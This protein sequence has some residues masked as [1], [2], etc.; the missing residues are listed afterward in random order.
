MIL[1]SARTRRR[2]GRT[3]S[4]VRG[5]FAAAAVLLAAAAVFAPAQQASAASTSCS[6]GDQAAGTYKNSIC[7]IDLA[8]YDSAL[9]Q[10][11]AGQPFDLTLDGGYQ[12]SF[13]LTSTGGGGGQRNFLPSALPVVGAPGTVGTL[14]GLSYVGTQGLPAL[15]AQRGAANSTTRLTISNIALTSPGGNPVNNFA[16]IGADAEFTDAPAGGTSQQEA[17]TWESNVPIDVIDHGTPSPGVNGCPI[18]VP[19]D[20]TTV[21]SCVP[22]TAAGEERAL[23]TVVRAIQ[24]TTF[25][26]NIY[27]GQAGEREAVAFGIMTAKVTLDKNVAGRISATDSFA[28][29]ITSDLDEVLGS[30]TTGTGPSSTTG[31]TVVVPNLPGGEFT[32]AETAE[33]GNLEEYTAAWTCT[34][35]VT[36]SSTTLPNGPGFQQV[37]VPQPGDDITCRIVNT[38]D[39]YTV[40]KT[41]SA[42]TGRA[43]DVLNYTITVTNTGPGDYTA[44]QPARLSDD[45]ADVLDDATYNGDATQGATVAGNTL[46]WSGPLASGQSLTIKYSVT[47][48]AAG[49]LNVRNTVLARSP[50]GSCD[51]ASACAVETLLVRPAGPQVSTGGSAGDSTGGSAGLSHTG[52]SVPWMPLMFGVLLALAGSAGL[53]VSRTSRER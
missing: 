39:S 53:F 17:I 1:S 47:A 42:T 19:G 44:N 23:A 31:S 51:P 52:G 15:Y 29:S 18:P 26:Q 22:T 45:L 11:P 3:P 16:F 27:H 4:R 12:L 35:T 38:P 41:V 37:L 34:N 8:S 50:G 48:S 43:G 28:T 24:P 32:L 10:T 5:F 7:W 14:G 6:Y 46:S 13:T 25:T 49:D 20:G 9:A 33:S 2:R 40:S 36:S 30:A 21:V